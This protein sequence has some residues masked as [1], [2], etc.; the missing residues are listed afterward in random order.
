MQEESQKP[1]IALIDDEPEILNALVRLFRHR[2]WLVL[3]CSDARTAHA[4]LTHHHLDLII[5]DYRMPGVDGVTLLNQFKQS[6][7]DALRLVLS[8]QADLEGVLNAVNDSE[9]Y[10]FI[11]KPWSNEDLLVTLDNALRYKQMALENRRLAETVRRQQRELEQ[12][13][14][15]LERLESEAPGITQVERDKDGFIIL[16]H[17]D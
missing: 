11:L 10:R 14:K 15:E 6:H 2:D 8:G 5:S 1:V 9:V 7:P 16:S 17:D 4:E 13:K 12:Q 3:T